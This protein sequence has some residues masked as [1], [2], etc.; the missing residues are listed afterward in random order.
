MSTSSNLFSRGEEARERREEETEMA[1]AEQTQEGGE[2][3]VDYADFYPD[4]DDRLLPYDTGQAA[5]ERVPYGASMNRRLEVLEAKDLLVKLMQRHGVDRKLEGVQAA[6]TSAVMLAHAKNSAS[7][8]VPGRATFYVGQGA[9][10]AEFNYFA[11]VVDILGDDTRRFFRA[12][13]NVVLK[14]VKQNL[15]YKGS[16]NPELAQHAEDL[17]WVAHDR[18]L[19]RVPH[20]AFDSAEACSGLT[21]WERNMISGAKAS[22]LSKRV[23]VADADRVIQ[24]PAIGSLEGGKADSGT[25]SAAKVGG[26]GY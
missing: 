18:G 14:V 13:S 7:V 17:L 20:L 16:R 10:R 6:F 24:A 19:S 4:V 11:D 9:N 1:F 12:Y 3:S 22:V 23:N 15:E 25:G 26:L 5:R 8:L 21:P 2:P